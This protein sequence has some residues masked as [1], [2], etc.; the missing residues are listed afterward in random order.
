MR[1]LLGAAAFI[2]LLLVAASAVAGPT[3]SPETPSHRAERLARAFHL[4]VKTA[5]RGPALIQLED[6]AT[7]SMPSGLA[8][9]PMTAAQACLKELGN[10]D[11]AT[12]KGLFVG[13]DGPDGFMMVAS[14]NK[15]GHIRD[16]D[17]KSLNAD[18][19]LQSL[20]SGIES[21]NAMRRETGAPEAEL[22]GWVEAPSYDSAK[23]LLVWALAVQRKGV[24]HPRATVNY[25]AHVLGRAG[26]V[27]LNMLTDDAGLK[28]DKPLAQ[29]LQNSLSY[30]KGERYEDFDPKTDKVAGHSLASLVLG[31]TPANAGLLVMVLLFLAKS[32]KLIAIGFVAVLGWIV[33]RF[34]N[35]KSTSVQDAS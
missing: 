27:S 30:L 13:S 34:F 7:V 10:D 29:R 26:G 32:F 8:F 11:D 12:V 25:T 17:A 21:A 28:R 6:Q 1:N 24:P 19:L 22:R 20:R 16:D 23:H 31:L 14:V 2:S 9:I 4:A 35:R 15:D 3:E 33:S 5:K 18:Q